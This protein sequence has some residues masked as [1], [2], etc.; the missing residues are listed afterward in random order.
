MFLTGLIYPLNETSL[1]L[2]Q[3][4]TGLF[5]IG[6]PSAINLI[7]TAISIK[8]THNTG[9][10]SLSLFFPIIFSYLLSIFRYN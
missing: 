3:Y 1:P 2:E 6:L 8:M 5:T 4:F 9:I 7:L 10:L